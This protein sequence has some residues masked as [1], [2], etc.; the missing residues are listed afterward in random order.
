[1]AQSYSQLGE[2]KLAVAQQERA[3]RMKRRS[4]SLKK[5]FARVA[6][7]TSVARYSILQAAADPLGPVV[8]AGS[9]VLLLLEL[10]AFALTLSY[11]FE[12]LDVLSR[13]GR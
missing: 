13:R 5:T 3:V 4:E 2:L 9:L 1:M 12:I 11:A 6:A 10:F 7:A 8:W